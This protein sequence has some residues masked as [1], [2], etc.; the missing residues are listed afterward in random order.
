MVAWLHAF[1]QNIMVV[2]AEQGRDW[3]PDIIF[4]VTSPVTKFL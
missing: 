2:G 3:R 4:E 1:G